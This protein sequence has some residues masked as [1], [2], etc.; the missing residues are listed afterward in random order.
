MKRALYIV[1]VIL[2]SLLLI[3]GILIGLLMSDVVENKVMQIVTE[4]FAHKLGTAV[5]VGKMEYRFPARLALHD[6]YVE[7]LQKDTLL[8]AGEVYAHFRPLALRQNELRFSHVRVEDAV[9]K[10]Y[11]VDSTEWNYQFIV[12]A[13]KNDEATKKDSSSISLISV[14]DVKLNNVRLDYENY[15]TQ[16]DH[17]TMDLHQLSD[18]TIDA[19]IRDLSVDVRKLGGIRDSA[20]IDSH[21]IVEDMKARV[22]MNDTILSVPTLKA[23]LPHSKADISGIEVHFPPG[24][25]LY[26]SKSAH[27]ILFV[28]GI[29][30]AEVVPSDL[31]F[32]IPKLNNLKRP[33]TLSGGVTGTLDSLAFDGLTLGYDGQTVLVGD[34]CAVGL[35]D[36]ENPYVRAN[37]TDVHTNAVQLQ[38]FLSQLQGRP[39]KMPKEVHRLGDIHYRGLAEGRIHDITLHGAFRTALG[40]ITTDGNFKS[41][42]VF[43]HMTF[44]A[45]MAGRKF[46]LGRLINLAQ[47]GTVSLDV[48][49]QGQIDSSEVRGDVCAHVRE[50]E[51]ND[52]TFNDLHIDG[53]YEPQLYK[54]ECEIHDPHLDVSFNGVVNLQARNP[55]IN[56]NL[57]CRHFDSAPLG[58]AALGNNLRTRFSVAVDMNGVEPDR[59]SGYLV[60]DSL[61]LATSHDSVLMKQMTL[62]ASAAANGNKSITLKTDYLKAQAD[63]HFRYQ[64]IIPSAQ[65]L[66][67]H[68]LPTAVESPKQAWQPVSIKMRMDGERLRDVQRLFVAPITLSDHPTLR[69]ETSIAEGKEPFFDL[70]FSAPG[71]RVANTPIH[72]LTV[73][74]NTVAQLM[75]KGAKGS[76]LALSVSAEAMKMQTVFSTLAYHDTLLTHLTLR[77][78]SQL[79]ELLPEGWEKLSPREL[80]HA[81][82]DD[83]TFREKQR[84]LVAAQRAGDYGGDI[85]AITHFSKYNDR[86]LI[87]VHFRPSIL[88]LRDSIYTLSESRL[89]Y[90][91]ADTTLQVDRFSFKGGGQHL[92]ANG[93]A[94]RHAHDTLTV[95]LAKIDASYVVPFVLPV[96]TIMFNGLLTGEANITSVFSKPQVDTQIHVDSMGL[97]NCYFGEADVDLHIKDSLAFHADVNRPDRKVVDLNGKAL[98]DGSGI[99]ELDMQA[100]S[101]PLEFINHW[102][103][104]VL[105]DLQGNGTG[106]VVVG[107]RKGLVYVLLRCAAKNSSFTLPWTGCRYT[108]PHDTIV[109]DTTAILFPNVHL[110]DA[111][112]HKVEVNGGVYHDQ[113][114]DF[115][116]DIHVDAHDAV[117]F[118]NDKKGDMIQGK[119]YATGHVDVTGDENDIL[120]SANARTSKNSRFRLSLDNI[121]SAYESNFIHFVEHKDELRIETKQKEETDLDNIDLV[122]NA[123]MDSSFIKRAR[124]LVKLNIEINPQ[125]LFQLVLGERNGDIIQGRGNG[126]LQLAYETETGDVSLLGSYELDQGTLSYT[127]AN[128]IRKE[129]TVGEGSTIVFSGDPSNPQLD[130]TAKYRVTANIRDLFG[131]EAEQLATSRSNIPVLTCLH[132]T[133]PLNNPVLTFALEFPLSDQ[134]IQQQVKQV[135]NTDEMLMRQVIYLLVFGRFFTPDYMNNSQYA[136]LNSTYSL[137]SST[138]TSQ[139]NAWLSKLTDMVTL[140][141]AI[142]SDGEGADASQEYE[143]QFQLHPVDRL[144]I[145]GNVGY[146]YNDISNQP[147]FGDLDVEVLLTEDGQLRL[148]G[149][150]HTVDKY[151]LRQASTIQGFGFMWKKDF[152]W[153]ASKKKKESK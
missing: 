93:L 120:V 81:L 63:G 129:F 31:A 100:N 110:V 35:P 42:S 122:E 123:K 59:M 94:S 62:L 109:M 144:V 148:K 55:E 17:S 112:G 15:S 135:I 11:R 49:S 66:L 87:D 130:V 36:I 80:Q 104:S 51:F 88:M 52:Y 139:I 75:H 79:D 5:K 65:A 56:C 68:Y 12:D 117:V 96:Q 2:V 142:R 53:R 13:F 131:E 77:H 44:D 132:M 27:D 64:D 8:Y 84:A 21:F 60:L 48:K 54:G 19:E 102:T 39:V 45:R 73:T 126:A 119:V 127:V 25:T 26:L 85:Q 150:T 101:V 9:A 33:V 23:Q 111:E 29:H 151:S 115:A 92:R 78:Q 134:A 147:F 61:F 76:G 22:I 146:R 143:A 125:L 133:G 114:R 70:R 140:G 58:I 46:R 16:I 128:V 141:V 43:E 90:C 152:N 20:F 149:Y 99:W 28:V 106:R 95:D 40:T 14:R 137:L 47:L 24:D 3:C 37:F 38:D 138:V 34:I 69:A 89:T 67:H 136:T 86:P 97:N 10:I 74:L 116:L 18:E 41:D 83:L 98:F 50:I 30:E 107:G 6:V 145:N 82:S 113:F 108:I 121:A 1:G 4:Q 7:D 32:F 124:C 105:Y 118:E 153:P 71:V 72:D 103:Q 57:R 91:A